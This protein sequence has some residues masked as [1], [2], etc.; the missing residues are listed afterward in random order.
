MKK[1]QLAICALFFMSIASKAQVSVNVNFGPPPVWAP[2]ER[3]ETQYYYLPDIDTYYDVPSARFIYIKNGSWF[4][5]AS[6][7]YRYRNY[8][9]RGGNVVY[10]TDYR[11]DSPYSYHKS[12]KIKYYKKIKYNEPVYVNRGENEGH[13]DEREHG[14][15]REHGK[16]K[17]H[18]K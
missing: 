15:E 3:V 10:L 8:N 4:R 13:H 16:G 7:P 17:G 5:S 14:E 11:G 2:A 6:L 9:L 18:K 12:H 1:I